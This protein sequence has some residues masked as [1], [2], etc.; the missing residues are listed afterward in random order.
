MKY[1]KYIVVVFVLFSAANFSIAAEKNPANKKA[2]KEVSAEKKELDKLTVENNLFKQKTV[3]KLR[4]L[5]EEKAEAK[6]KYDLMMEKQ[7]I[8]MAELEAEQKLLALENKL[9]SEKNKK[10]LTELRQK[11][12]KIKLENESQL[13]L[14]KLKNAKELDSINLKKKRMDFEMS[15]LRIAKEKMVAEIAKLKIDLDLRQKKEE[16]KNAANKEPEYLLNPFKNGVLTISDRRIP[17]NGPIG[18]GMANFITDRIH[19]FNNKSTKLPIFIVINDSPGGS[20]QEGFRILKAIKTSQAP[21][22]V[23]VKSYAASMAAIIATLAPYSY[24][25]PNAIIL[26]HEVSAMTWGNMTQMKEQLENIKEWEKRAVTPIAKKMGI[27]MTA[28]RKRMYEHNSD[29]NWEEFADKAVKYK[30]VNN[31]VNEI[32][33]TGYIKNPDASKKIKSKLYLMQQM[34]EKGQPYVKLP[35]LNP[36]DFYYI[37]NPDNYYR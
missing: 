6:A 19:Y 20:A 16:W 31:L 1:I 2:V 7:K 27:S 18:R 4:A 24:A 33:E 25:Y 14:A 3:K 28:F 23:V 32:R 12:A 9:M 22:H 10:A 35:R 29:G 37:Y 36:F 5:V 13:E 8:K 34:D 26:H 11:N 15:K 30:W 17:L 21:I